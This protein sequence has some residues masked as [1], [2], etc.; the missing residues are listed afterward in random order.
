MMDLL[1]A[2][3]VLRKNPAFAAVAVL[4]LALGIGSTTAVFTVVNA[5]LLRPL[6]C[7]DPDRLATILCPP[8]A[9]VSPADYFDFRDQS[10]AFESVAAAEAWGADLTGRDRPEHLPGLRMTLE[11]QSSGFIRMLCPPAAATS[12]SKSPFCPGWT[13]SIQ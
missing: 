1:Y 5:V 8:A 13:A 12:K 9:P 3:R 11:A 6:P 2:L 10:R 7:R 4:T